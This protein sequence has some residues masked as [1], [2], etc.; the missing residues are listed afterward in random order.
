MKPKRQIKTDL[1]AL[2][3]A[4]AEPVRLR[5]ML[6]LEQEELSVGELAD[7][8]QLPQSTTSRHLKVLGDA[9][10]LKRRSA[11]PAT[12]FKL[13]LDDL[14]P[15]ARALW[16]AVREQA[17][18]VSAEDAHRLAG[19]LAERKLD[20]QTFFGR[21]AGEWDQVRTHL[22]GAEFTLRALLALLPR[23]WTVADL[24]CGTGNASELLAPHVQRIIAVD[25]SEAML[26]AAR[27][28]LAGLKN[29]QF[30]PGD[31]EKL[32]LQPASVDA[33]VCDLVLHHL[34]RPAAAIAEMARV[35]RPDRAGA[36]GVALIV[37][38]VEHKRED[39]R[40][41]MGHRHLGFASGTISGWMNDAGFTDVRIQKM[42]ADPEGRGPGLFVATGRVA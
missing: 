22:F 35:L 39:F 15:E 19:V 3:S 1:S 36:G 40:T 37:D 34:E 14:P 20:S 29:V 12:I 27:K 42:A 18:P 7:V 10:L 32:P 11:G 5:L 2:L 30:L 28:R 26:A 25:S 13:V 24:G 23:R 38:M 4:L 41:A 17:G 6:V 21:I 16:L 8:V 31:L 9:G 33:V